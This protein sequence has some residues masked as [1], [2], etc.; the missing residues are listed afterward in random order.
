ML[1]YTGPQE[2]RSENWDCSRLYVPAKTHINFTK[3]MTDWQQ[4]YWQQKTEDN[5]ID[6]SMDEKKM[7][8]LFFYISISSYIIFE[9]ESYRKTFSDKKRLNLNS[10]IPQT[11]PKGRTYQKEGNS[12]QK[13]SKE[14][15][16]IILWHYVN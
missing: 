16:E 1:N 15:K 14:I 6:S 3:E 12:F 2:N 9:S 7:T 10:Q 4:S 13:D 11:I 8:V 5:G